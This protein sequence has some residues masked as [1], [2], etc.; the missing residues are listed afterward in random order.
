MDISKI[1][2][3]TKVDRNG[4]KV[5]QGAVSSSGYGNIVEDGKQY[6]A[7]EYAWRCHNGP[8]PK[9]KLLRHR[10]HNKLCCNEKHLELGTA[11]DNYHD[12]EDVH[13]KAD[14]KRRG[15]W[16]VDNISYD[17]AKQAVEKTGISMNSIIKFTK[18]GRFD[19]S[20]YEAACKIAGTY[21]AKPKKK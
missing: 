9:G 13:A 2:Q 12:S 8:V 1:E 5:W 7:H 21:P 18:K 17:T 16:I 3:N 10:C 6:T 19:R 11:K 14:A 15:T 20:A 4:C